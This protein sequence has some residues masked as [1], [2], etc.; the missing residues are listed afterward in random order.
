MKKYLP[1]SIFLF[2]TSFLFGQPYGNE[3][4]DYNKTYYKI[5]TANNAL[6]RVSGQVLQNAGMNLSSVDPSKMK[7]FYYGE[8]VPMYVS[9]TT[10]FGINDF[11][12]FYGAR[13]D[14]RYD[15]QLYADPS[16]QPNQKVSVVIDSS[17]Y[18]LMIDDTP[19][20]LRIEDRSNNIANPPPAE[21][22]F[23]FDRQIIYSNRHSPGISYLGDGRRL[24]SSLFEPSEGYCSVANDSISFS[25]STRNFDPDPHTAVA[26]FKLVG[27]KE[28]VHN[29]TIRVNGTE[30]FS[31]TFSN[32]GITEY[33]VPFSSSLFSGNNTTV[34]IDTDR[35]SDR[36]AM[37]YINLEYRKSFNFENSPTF[38]FQLE[39]DPVDGHFLDVNAFRERDS[40]PL[41]VDL[42]N[43]TRQETVIDGTGFQVMLRPAV[44]DYD[45][46]C[47]RARFLGYSL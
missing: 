45:L 19:S 1:L 18:F 47:N 30:I 38:K 22:F 12:E 11:I 41:I 8:E 4:I 28:G 33:T 27:R 5:T 37:S 32:F 31:T 7:L 40:N 16:H 29:V 14:G 44:L 35:A 26:T 15:T 46:F 20:S 21:D 9:S 25:V 17:A 13:N 43:L 42:N 23:T 36:I 10:G 3:W 2:I 6:V 34:T 39:A 24:F